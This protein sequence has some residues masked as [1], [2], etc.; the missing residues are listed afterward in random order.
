MFVFNLV[1]RKFIQ[2]QTRILTLLHLR[3]LRQFQNLSEETCSRA[4]ENF[5]ELS[6]VAFISNK[7]KKCFILV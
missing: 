5:I 7:S 3:Y 6:F 4:T 2:Q 1:K